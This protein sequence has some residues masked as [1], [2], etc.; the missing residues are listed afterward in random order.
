M[1]FQ[2]E[3]MSVVEAIASSPKVAAI[4]QIGTVSMGTAWFAEMLQGTMSILAIGGGV[5][6]TLLLIRVHWMTGKKIALENR[7]LRQQ[8]INLGIDLTKEES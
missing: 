4:V 1:K 2:D 7:I 5:V 3:L 6:A 8:A